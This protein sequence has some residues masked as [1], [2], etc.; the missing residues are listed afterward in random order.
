MD[1]RR[2]LTNLPETFLPITQATVLFG[3]A[4]KMLLNQDTILVN[5]PHIRFLGQSQPDSTHTGA[6]SQPIIP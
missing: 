4:Y 2:Y 5:S 3:A 1:I 6:A